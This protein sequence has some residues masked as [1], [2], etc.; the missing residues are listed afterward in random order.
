VDISH[1]IDLAN[2]GPSRGIAVGDVD[3]D[4][5]PDMLISNQWARSQFL[6]NTGPGRAYLG[7]R[8][9]LPPIAGVPGAVPR[10]AIGA[11]VTVTKRDGKV[12]RAQLFPAN[13]HT[14]VNAPE[15]LF[16]LG[17]PAD[18][19]VEVAVTWRDVDGVHLVN[20]KLNSGW[21]DITLDTTTT[22]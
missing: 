14:G 20:R 7:L 6:R 2:P 11:A 22:R 19:P 5:R 17:P 10:P 4:G 18:N 15:L 8:L 16:G 1:G 12:L 21:H 13:G 9:L 3:H